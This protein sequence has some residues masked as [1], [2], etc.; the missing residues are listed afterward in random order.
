LSAVCSTSASGRPSIRSAAPTSGQSRP[1]AAFAASIASRSIISIAAGTIPEA[2]MAETA[3]P[4]SSVEGNVAKKVRVAWGFLRIRSTISVTMPII[5]SLPT[6]TPRRSYPGA[7]RTGPPRSTTLPS[8][9][10]TRA[11]RT[12]FVV[13]P[14]FRQCA[15]PEFSATL[16]PIVQTLCEEGSGA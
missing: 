8:A 9:S 4:A 6:R 5:P 13:K 10:T 16:P 3:L 12:W 7:S 1:V 11:P 14:Y 2:M 15:P